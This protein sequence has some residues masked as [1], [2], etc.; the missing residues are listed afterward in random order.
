MAFGFSTTA[1]EVTEG[2]D[3]TGR[4]YLVTGANS[5]L[6]RET[7]RVL[8]LRGA[9]VVAGARTEE[10]ARATLQELAI[11]GTPLAVDL[12]SLESVAAAT[13]AVDRP[14]H[15]IIANAGIMALQ[16][17]QT[18]AGV[19]AQLFTNHVG[20]AALVSG[21]LD[22]L[23]PD[24]RVVIVSSAAHRMA[25]AQGVDLHDPS[26]ATDY[27]PWAAYGQSKLAN[28]LFARALATRLPEGQT[29]NSLHPGVIQTNLGRHV[30]D[31]DAMYARM[32]KIL[33]TVGQGAATQVWAAT[34]PELAS[35]T[36]AY[37]DDCQVARTKHDKATD[38]TLAEDLWAWTM[39]LIAR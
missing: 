1:E 39:A 35:T 4:T 8:A 36:G 19:E 17:Q 20:H 2:L 13:E 21:L 22:R 38:D 30:P 3:L 27:T 23:T 29:A 24:G 37:L 5:G 16:E 9:H 26:F 34:H 12:G 15:G 14:L 32:E 6:G 11:D 7:T 31:P 25:P 18:I 33:K 28:I 10:K